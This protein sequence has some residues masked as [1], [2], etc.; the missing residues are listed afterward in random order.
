MPWPNKTPLDRVR[1]NHGDSHACKLR[2]FGQPRRH[3]YRPSA[4]NFAKDASLS[5]QPRGK[6]K[7]FLAIDLLNA[8][9]H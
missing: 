1:Q 9:Q 3:C 6:L 5:H 2:I 7:G 8:V 4:G